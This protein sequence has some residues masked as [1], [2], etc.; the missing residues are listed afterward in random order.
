MHEVRQQR[1]VIV[2]QVG[3]LESECAF[4]RPPIPDQETARL[5]W[6][7]QQ[8]MRIER[9]RIGATAWQKLMAHARAQYE[10]PAIRGVDMQPQP[11]RLT[12]L[13]QLVDRIDG[14][15]RDRP[16]TGDHTERCV[17][18]SAVF[19]YGARELVDAQLTRRVGWN[20]PHVVGAEPEDRGALLDALMRLG[21]GVRHERR[22]S[23][24]QSALSK[25]R[26]MRVQRRRQGHQSRH[27]A[28]AGEEPA[29]RVRVLELRGQPRDHVLFDGV[30]RR[31]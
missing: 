31:R 21:R 3:S 12:E 20:P 29:R 22:T 7:E 25:S 5:E 4:E 23:A 9:D 13:R 8:L 2:G 6:C 24:L 10:Q 30:R 17:T 11:V 14:A 26:C 15:R 18:T 16:G 19:V 28:A 27:R 1:I